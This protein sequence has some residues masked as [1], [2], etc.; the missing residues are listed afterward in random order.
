M[1][2]YIALSLLYYKRSVRENG[3][4][5]TIIKNKVLTITFVIFSGGLFDI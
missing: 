3:F 4:R 5:T 1:Y 2:I